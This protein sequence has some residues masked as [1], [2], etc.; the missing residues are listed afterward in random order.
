MTADRETKFA[1]LRPLSEQ[2][3][4]TC[5]TSLRGWTTWDLFKAKECYIRRKYSEEM[6]LK[7]RD[8]LLDLL[9]IVILSLR[10]ENESSSSFKIMKQA[11]MK[12]LNISKRDNVDISNE[13][14]INLYSKMSDQD[15]NKVR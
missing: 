11:V 4:F 2:K 10:M 1:L 6:Q 13:D 14:I 12:Y 5:I 15:R 9:K 8:E 3:I 7:G